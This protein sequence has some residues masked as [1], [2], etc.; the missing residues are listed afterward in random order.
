LTEGEK[1]MGFF[2]KLTNAITG[3][4]I[5]V[6][7]Q[8]S[9]AVLGKPVPVRVSAA[10]TREDTDIQEVTIQV[11]AN[12]RVTVRNVVL[13]EKFGEQVR[14]KHDDVTQ[15]NT[16]FTRKFTVAGPQRLQT[17]QT[18]EWTGS[19]DIPVEER[20]TFKGVNAFHTWQVQA[21]VETKGN[22]PDSGWMEIAV[23]R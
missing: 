21:A 6:T 20:P 3:G 10:V 22:N 19:F 2:S 12:E 9:E 16:T 5:K 14:E 11:M 13:A 4:G 18:Y 17:G 8:C 15:V 23:T 1:N 7:L